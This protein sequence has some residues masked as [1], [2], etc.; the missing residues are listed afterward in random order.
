MTEGCY[1]FRLIGMKSS[2]DQ[3]VS[4]LW[5]KVEPVLVDQFKQPLY[6]LNRATT[7]GLFQH[8]IATYISILI[9][10]LT[11]IIMTPSVQCFLKTFCLCRRHRV[12]INLHRTW[13]LRN[14][15]I[16]S[17]LIVLSEQSVSLL[18]WK[19]FYDYVRLSLFSFPLSILQQM[20]LSPFS[21]PTQKTQTKTIFSLC[22]CLHI[23]KNWPQHS[24]LQDLPKVLWPFYFIF[25][26]IVYPQPIWNTYLC[27]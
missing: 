20:F 7:W 22:A 12:H 26:Y 3:M 27:I 16:T 18:N 4:V 6:E 24:T 11:N 2:S 10:S 13:F 15:T 17:F 21:V 23:N 25:I 1:C 9:L 14:F 19:W 5:G 8:F